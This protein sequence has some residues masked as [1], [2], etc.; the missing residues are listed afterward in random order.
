MDAVSN[1]LDQFPRNLFFQAVD[2]QVGPAALPESEVKVLQNKRYADNRRLHTQLE[3]LLRALKS[4]ESFD[5]MGN[6][7]LAAI[8]LEELSSDVH[9]QI[10][11]FVAEIESAEDRYS[12]ALDAERETPAEAVPAPIAPKPGPG[13]VVAPA[14][15]LYLTEEAYARMSGERTNR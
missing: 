1:R 11:N 2:H 3:H 12:G 7:G 5:P 6:A 8:N 9:K 13:P 10:K 15:L 14:P 4:V